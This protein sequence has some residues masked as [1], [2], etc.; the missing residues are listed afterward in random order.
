MDTTQSK[1]RLPDPIRLI[2]RDR[3]RTAAFLRSVATTTDDLLS[4]LTGCTSNV[5]DDSFNRDMPTE[6][7]ST[8]Q[9]VLRRYRFAIL[10]LQ[11][12]RMNVQAIRKFWQE[13]P[14]LEEHADGS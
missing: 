10:H 2:A 8:V 5:M 7:F 11:E 1:I 12:A 4:Q 3:G 13:A 14:A 9:A 6:A